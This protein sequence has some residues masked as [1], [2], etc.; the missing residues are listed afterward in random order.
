MKLP[1]VNPSKEFMNTTIEKIKQERIISLHIKGNKFK[2]I[3]QFPTAAIFNNIT[4][5]ILDNLEHINQ[6]NGIRTYFSNLTCS[7]LCYENQINFHRI[8]KIFNLIPNSVKLFKIHC[9][10]ISCSHGH[11]NI[12]LI[13]WNE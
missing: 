5:L 4:L 1:I 6:I 13:H 12:F 2:S 9:G 10:L 8:R 3:I 11:I 7:S